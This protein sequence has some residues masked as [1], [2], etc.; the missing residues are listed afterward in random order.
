MSESPLRL[1]VAAHEPGSGF[2]CAMQVLSWE[3]GDPNL[4]PYPANV[5]RPLARMVQHVN[6]TA[7]AHLTQSF[8]EPELLCASCSMRVMELAH[9]T[10][11]TAG[12]TRRSQ[13]RWVH[14]LLV[15]EHGIIHGSEDPQVRA[16][17]REAGEATRTLEENATAAVPRLPLLPV[18]EARRLTFASFACNCA[19]SQ[20][21][22]FLF[23]NAGEAYVD[24]DLRGGSLVTPPSNREIR[25]TAA[26]QAIDAWE[27]ATGVNAPEPDPVALARVAEQMRELAAA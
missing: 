25:M 1:A 19:R 9:R 11:D 10:V 8:G 17:I 24:M 23:I 2:A 26:G 5:A 15:G 16:R 12:I 3:Q 4:D 7:C 20:D 13:W 18:S 14:E 6:D 27:T 22:A 21:A